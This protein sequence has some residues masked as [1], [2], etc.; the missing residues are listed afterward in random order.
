MGLHFL[1]CNNKPDL[2]HF[3]EHHLPRERAQVLFLLLG[4]KVLV[5]Q[6]IGQYVLVWLLPSGKTQ[7][8]LLV[9]L[10]AQML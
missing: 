8:K 4:N 6:D 7:Y 2:L 3:L 5:L 1:V 10:S 9:R